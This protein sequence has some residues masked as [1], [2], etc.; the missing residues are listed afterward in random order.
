MGPVLCAGVGGLAAIHGITPHSPLVALDGVHTA[1][2]LH[3]ERGIRP[4]VEKGEPR[5]VQ[6]IGRC[7]GTAVVLQ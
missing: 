2:D 1:E 3:C 5:N 4:A 6:R 7:S